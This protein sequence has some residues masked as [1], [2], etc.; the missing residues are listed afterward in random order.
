MPDRPQLELNAG[1]R[2]TRFLHHKKQ[3]RSPL[4]HSVFMPRG[5]EVSIAHIAALAEPAVWTLGAQTLNPAAGR[6]QLRGRAD[7]DVADVHAAG[8]RAIR[9]DIGYQRHGAIVG[10]P[11]TDDADAQQKE[12]AKDLASAATLV[13]M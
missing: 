1:Q 7:L 11:S 13:R 3:L 8:L 4:H 10:W 9:D 2:I 5:G 6:Q 12:L